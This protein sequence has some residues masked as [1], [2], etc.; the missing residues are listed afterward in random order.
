MGLPEPRRSAGWRLAFRAMYAA[1]GIVDPL[2]RAWWRRV[3]LGNVVD[4]QVAGRRSGRTRPVLLG[5]LRD[6]GQWFLGH[7]NGEVAWTRN[8]AAA[9]EAT[10]VL[11]PGRSIH[12]RATRLGPGESRDR[13]IRATSQ[14]V[15]PGSL[16]YRLAWA[17]IRA[18][19]AY[20]E[21]EPAPER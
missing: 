2:V 10:V 1:L 18:V 15:F 14:H 5:L 3:P 19:G 21:I 8:L 6:G 17:H 7:P 9:G 20:F 13:A 12:V 16:I 11:R 4:L